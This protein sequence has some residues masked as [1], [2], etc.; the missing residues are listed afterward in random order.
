MRV[1]AVDA[2]GNADTTARRG[3][4][5]FARAAKFVDDLGGD[6]LLP[7][8]VQQ[9]GVVGFL[10][11]VSG[12]TYYV[13]ASVDQVYNAVGFAVDL[14]RGRVAVDPTELYDALAFLIEHPEVVRAIPGAI[15]DSARRAQALQN[16][17]APHDFPDS[18]DPFG[19]NSANVTFAAGWYAGGLLGVAAE[20]VLTA[21]VGSAAKA[22]GKSL[23]VVNRIIRAGGTASSL[24]VGTP[25]GVAKQGALLTGQAVA[26]AIGPALDAVTDALERVAVSGQVAVRKAVNQVGDDALRTVRRAD[27]DAALTRTLT[28]GD[29]RAA[30]ALNDLDE[31]TIRRLLR[32]VDCAGGGVAAR[33]IVS[34]GAVLPGSGGQYRMGH[35]SAVPFQAHCPVDFDEISD[36]TLDGAVRTVLRA[37]DRG[38]LSR[39]QASRISERLLD[40]SV[41]AGVLA[42]TL[43]NG[44]DNAARFVA[45]A[46]ADALARF[47]QL[48]DDAEIPEGRLQTFAQQTDSEG[49]NLVGSLEE[50]SD[51]DALE[52]FF[53]FGGSTDLDEGLARNVRLRLVEGHD[54]DFITAAGVRDSA[55][56]LAEL[57]G[58]AQVSGLDD[59]AR[60]IIKG[61]L[62]SDDIA[63]GIEFGVNCTNSVW[64][65]GTSWTNWTRTIHCD[66]S[67]NRSKINSTGGTSTT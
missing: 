18:G 13:A 21:G 5:A 61:S 14:L 39:A 25:L 34:G 45:E 52:T 44:D 60:S 2:H 11:A 8:D 38:D 16:P 19:V 64:Q 17:F 37:K 66:F 40:D 9:L 1:R 28:L 55:T 31:A 35:P 22:V 57:E 10:A 58:R 50:L 24:L 48:S 65:I 12:F 59:V 30:R 47:T 23:P 15:V 53:K 54:G 7:Q 27:L 4:N 33:L 6:R 63:I 3:P 42:R 41:D 43:A 29:R 62:E 26:R 46:D 36:E 56:D 49:A 67:S 32:V 51:I 20:A